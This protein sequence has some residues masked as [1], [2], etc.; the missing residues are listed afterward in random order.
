MYGKNKYY[1][2]E[3]LN[4]LDQTLLVGIEKILRVSYDSLEDEERKIF[5]DISLF[6]IVEESNERIKIW[7]GSR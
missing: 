5:L 4:V 2:K 6:F 7:G 1:R 3:I